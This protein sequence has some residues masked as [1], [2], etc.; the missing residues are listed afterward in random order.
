M[1]H[2]RSAELKLGH[3]AEVNAH[4]C[5]ANLRRRVQQRGGEGGGAGGG[6]LV[7]LRYPDGVV[8]G[9]RTPQIYI[10]SL[11][12]YDASLAFNG[13]VL[14]GALAAVAKWVVDVHSPSFQ[15]AMKSGSRHVTFQ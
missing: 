2:A 5:C 1:L 4:L 8:G 7:P 6:G 14:N 11:G 3:T 12:K 13:V 15:A 10:V 9:P